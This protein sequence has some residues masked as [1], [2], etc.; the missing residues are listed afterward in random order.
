MK[1]KTIFAALPL[2]A[3]P[4]LGAVALPAQAETAGTT[5]TLAVQAEH[6]PKVSVHL[7]NGANGVQVASAIN[8]IRTRNRPD[9][10]KQAVDAAFEKSGGR[11]NV[12]IINLS[13]EF[14]Q[15]L[16]GKRLFANIEFRNVRYALWIAESG[17]FINRGD[18]GWQN[19][20]FK[21]WYDRNGNTVKF[22]KP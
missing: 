20:G 12:I 11:F 10:V 8:K 15:N 6:V 18:G 22:R 7:D 16:N 2:V 5:S 19:W 4:L 3:L 9:F 13:Q 1:I 17:E 21:G 14:T